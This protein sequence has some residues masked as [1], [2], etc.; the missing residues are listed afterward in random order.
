MLV[1]RKKFWELSSLIIRCNFQSINDK[2]NTSQFD[3]KK[4]QKNASQSWFLYEY[5]KKES[6][7]DNEKQKVRKQKIIII[8]KIMSHPMYLGAL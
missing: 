1:L 6:K 5:E 8:K 7:F 4:E 2:R 3:K